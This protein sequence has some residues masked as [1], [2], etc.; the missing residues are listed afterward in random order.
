[1]NAIKH[2]NGYL[3]IG[4]TF[5]AELSQED[6]DILCELKTPYVLENKSEII[7][8][9]HIPLDMKKRYAQEIISSRPSEEELDQKYLSLHDQL[10]MVELEVKDIRKLKKILTDES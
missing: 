8:E 10:F 6:W 1:M 2:T 3:R 7:Y 9:E 4:D 5:T